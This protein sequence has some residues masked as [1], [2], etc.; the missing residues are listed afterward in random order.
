MT[1][2]DVTTAPATGLFDRLGGFD[3]I[4]RS[5]GRLLPR[6]AADPVLSGLLPA[7]PG[8]DVAWQVQMLLTDRLGGPM[9]YDG[10]DLRQLKERLGVNQ[11]QFR[12]L[13]GHTLACLA[14]EAG[15]PASLTEAGRLL[16]SVA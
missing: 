7:E 10:P 11:G 12:A 6:I 1:S 5:V 8:G 9:A 4:E 14:V 13:V 15:D 3:A 16:E 2:P